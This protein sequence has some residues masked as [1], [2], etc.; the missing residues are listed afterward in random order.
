MSELMDKKTLYVLVAAAA[1][2][3]VFLGSLIWSGSSSSR[4]REIRKAHGEMT[5]VGA[6]LR[7]L[8]ARSEFLTRKVAKAKDK[9]LLSSIDAIT[10]SIGIKDKLASQKSV[11]GGSV[12]EEKADLKFEKLSLNETANLFYRIDAQ[13]M[14]LLISRVTMAP[15]FDKPDLLMVDMTVSLVK[16]SNEKN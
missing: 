9:S 10:E 16:P 13:P 5:S 4:L 14:L 3:L 15:S 6:E 12:S 7:E 8:K 2:V 1:S 11:P